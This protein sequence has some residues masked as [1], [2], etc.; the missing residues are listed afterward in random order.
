VVVLVLGTAA[1]FAALAEQPSLEGAWSGGGT[2]SFASGASERAH[3]RASFRRQSANTF[4]MSAVCATP[5]GRVAQ[6][7]RVERVGPNRFAGAFYNAEY[8]VSGQIRIVLTA[9]RIRASLS[10]GAGSARLSLSR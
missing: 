5:S 10:A 1:A 6:T 4:G 2:V 7:A 3:C 8:G 9:N